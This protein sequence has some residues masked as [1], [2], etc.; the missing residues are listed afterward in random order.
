MSSLGTRLQEIPGA[1]VLAAKGRRGCRPAG[2]P[3]FAEA[4]RAHLPAGLL[5][6]EAQAG[7]MLELPGVAEDSQEA[8]FPS[9]LVPGRSS[10]R[11]LSRATALCPRWGWPSPTVEEGPCALRLRFLPVTGHWAN[12]AASPFCSGNHSV[13]APRSPPPPEA[14]HPISLFSSSLC[15]LFCAPAVWYQNGHRVN[16]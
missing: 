12:A 13:S 7:I 2:A 15:P 3:A 16:R 8:A 14:E 1:C 6:P 9:L 11:L 5:G 10:C 4:V